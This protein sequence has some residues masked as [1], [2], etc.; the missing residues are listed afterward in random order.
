MNWICDS[1]QHDGVVA[2]LI[3][4]YSPLQFTY[5]A[6]TNVQAQAV[7]GLD[8]TDDPFRDYRYEDPFNISFDEESTSDNKKTQ[9]TTSDAFGFNNSSTSDKQN[10]FDPFGLDGRQ[11]VPLPISDPFVS[12]SGRVSAP[13]YSELLSEDQQLAWAARESLKLEE[14]R[15]KRQLQ[16][17]ADLELAISLSKAERYDRNL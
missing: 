1:A 16:E 10:K 5:N 9:S 3:I 13:L 8:F 4:F 14:V 6:T 7:K 12:V 15:K 17:Q 2:T 11:S